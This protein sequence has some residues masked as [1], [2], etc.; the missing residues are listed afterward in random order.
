[1]HLFLLWSCR[2]R[3]KTLSIGRCWGTKDPAFRQLAELTTV[4]ELF[5]NLCPFLKDATIKAILAGCTSL[6]R[7]VL[8]ADVSLTIESVKALTRTGS[9]VRLQVGKCPLINKESVL[10]ISGQSEKLQVKYAS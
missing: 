6:N 1:M 2:P 3:L 9:K 7:L 5:L 10:E 4:Q 8:H